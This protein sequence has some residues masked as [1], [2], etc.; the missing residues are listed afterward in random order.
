MIAANRIA[1]TL[2]LVSISSMSARVNRCVARLRSPKR[3]LAS[4][5]A[6]T[7][8]LLYVFNGVMIVLTRKAADPVLLAGWL[9]GGMAIYALFHFVRA[10]WQ[11][12]DARLGLSPAET[13]WIGRAPLRDHELILYRLAGIAPATLIKSLLIS[14]V[15]F[16]DVQS[17]LRLVTA[18]FLAMMLLELVRVVA[19]RFASALSSRGRAAMRVAFTAITVCVV[20]QLLVRTFTGASGS[21]HPL[22]LLGAFT[23]ACGE[24]AGSAVV[25]WIALPWW[26]LTQVAM[27]PQWNLS[28]ALELGVSMLILTAFVVAVI[29][30]DRWATGHQ[31]RVEAQRL[32]LIRRGL[33]HA[34][35]TGDS[36]PRRV[37]MTLPHL[38]G[39]GPMIAR[40]W[41]SVVRYRGTILV[42]LLAPAG[43]SLA[44]LVTQSDAGMLHV[45]A[46]LAVC[47]LLL[48][49]PALRVDFRRDIERMW[50]LRSL[51]I[52]PLAMTL[53]QIALPAIV[54]IVFQIVVIA[55]AC[56]MSPTSISSVVLVLGAL[57][58]LAITSFALENI[59]FLTFPHRVKQEGLAMMVRAKL[60]FLGKGLLL[61]LVG[62][63]FIAWVTL[64]TENGYAMAILVSGWV[65]ASWAIAIVAVLATA[66]CWKR[67]DAHFDTPWLH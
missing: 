67:F 46:W 55:A 22:A 57:S 27:A 36:Q 17:P 24:T 33:I 53:G 7:F 58:G 18:L 10:A 28:V 20:I 14:V 65:L 23:R 60:V 54:T 31:H 37:L 30:I 52:T 38:G 26:P 21:S 43:L 48:A 49:P 25:Q 19:D 39:V 66:R 47:T 42:S 15:M 62:G 40:Q 12:S 16:C 29:A 9:S 44:P 35:S 13:L 5:A 63:G 41:V 2:W 32:D 61:G 50:L 51:P 59:L 4:L 1:T 8:L 11:E 6:A 56:L 45:G 64:C 3:L 34:R